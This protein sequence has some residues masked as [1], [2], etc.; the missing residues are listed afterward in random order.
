MDGAFCSDDNTGG[1]GCLAR[2]ASCEV[3]FAAAGFIQHVTEAL[4]S[5]GHALL[6]GLSIADQLGMGRVVFETD[7]ISL[8]KAVTTDEFDADPLGAMCL[9]MQNSISVLILLT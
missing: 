8:K 2:D 1:W 6:Q 4:Q 9:A 5:E 7:C 3:L